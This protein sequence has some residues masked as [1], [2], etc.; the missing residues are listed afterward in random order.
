MNS[1]QDTVSVDISIGTLAVLIAGLHTSYT[2]I[3]P[4]A[5][6][7]SVYIE[8][9]EKISEELPSWDYSKY[10]FEDWIQY[11]LL[12]APYQMFSPEEIKELQGNT[13]YYERMNGNAVLV[14][15]WEL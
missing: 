6:P 8:I 1:L 13:V 10:S 9:A 14:I 2:G 15:S 3:N 7:S 12:I 11:S 4:S 5:I